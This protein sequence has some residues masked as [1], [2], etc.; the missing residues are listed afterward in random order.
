[1]SPETTSSDVV[2]TAVARL[3]PGVRAP[4]SGVAATERLRAIVDAHHDFTWRSLRR[5][6]VPT[7]DVDDAVQRVFLVIA[8]RLADVTVGSERAFLF[9]T[10]VREAAHARRTLARR[11]EDG[12]DALLEREDGVA[13]ADDLVA[14]RQ[15]RALLDWLLD[16]MPLELRAVFVLFE[17]EE[18]SSPEIA[19]ML[20]LPLGTVASRLRRA[21]EDFEA[22]I[23][24]HRARQE[25]GG[26]P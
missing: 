1:M 4:T 11:R 17:I 25:R 24:R 9:S 21:R 16:E 7:A 8:N 20:D 13:P 12:D 22:R 10:A 19:A 14:Q 2:S 18:L 5:L 6:G 23:A 26:A 3:P 15:A